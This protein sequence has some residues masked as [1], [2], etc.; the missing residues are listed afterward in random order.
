[1]LKQTIAAALSLCSLL[2]AAADLPGRPVTPAE[3]AARPLSIAPDGRNLPPGQGTV[4]SGRKV[5]LMQCAGCHGAN[6]EG[7][8]DFPALVGGIGTLATAKPV[9]TIGSFWPYAT[10]VW[11]YINRAMP[12][13]SPGS[14]NADE[15]YGLTAYLLHLNGIVGADGTLDAASLPKVRMP[16]RDGFVIDPR[17]GAKF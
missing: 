4:V 13:Q 8:D 11:D 15:V 1:M 6:G 10:G 12:Y 14:L 16:N 7:N 17:P 9:Q 3:L 5:Y 2:A